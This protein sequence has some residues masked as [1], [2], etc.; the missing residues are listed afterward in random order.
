MILMANNNWKLPIIL[1]LE[2]VSIILVSLESNLLYIEKI[3]QMKTLNTT[4]KLYICA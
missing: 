2:E 4:H 1:M 3:K